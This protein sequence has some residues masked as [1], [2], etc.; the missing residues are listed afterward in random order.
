LG[1]SSFLKTNTL[2][3][4]AVSLAA[5]GRSFSVG[6]GVLR[7][8][9]F[10]CMVYYICNCIGEKPESTIGFCVGACSLCGLFVGCLTAVYQ[11]PDLEI[12][13]HTA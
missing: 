5:G 10:G 6:A 3:E 8:K 9:G 1:K 4:L 12:K 11:Y 13:E 2:F 7:M